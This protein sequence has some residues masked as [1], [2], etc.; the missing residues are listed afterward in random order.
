VISNVVRVNFNWNCKCGGIKKLS[1]ENT[2][3]KY[4][5]NENVKKAEGKFEINKDSMND[6]GY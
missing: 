5:Q 2:T 1:L 6:N 3:E 4:G